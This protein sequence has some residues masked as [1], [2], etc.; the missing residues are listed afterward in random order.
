M[1]ACR[2]V[3]Y[4]SPMCSCLMSMP[5]SSSSRHRTKAASSAIVTEA[6]LADK[7]RVNDDRRT[8]RWRE[9]LAR[10]DQRLNGAQIRPRST[11]SAAFRT[12]RFSVIFFGLVARDAVMHLGR[13]RARASRARRG[14]PT[15]RRSASAERCGRFGSWHI[16]LHGLRELELL[17]HH[18]HRRHHAVFQLCRPPNMM[19]VIMDTVAL[20]HTMRVPVDE[21][22]DLGE[23]GY[24]VL[25]N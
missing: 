16:V 3:A 2:A 13:T 14:C 11:N 20:S 8:G 4:L 7:D 12:L 5:Y 17:G 19:L 1:Q 22:V 6:D 10:L 18:P 23:E 15:C 21:Q 9:T 24:V 25:E